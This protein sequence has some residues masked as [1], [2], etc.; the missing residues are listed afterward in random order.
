MNPAPELS[1]SSPNY[2]NGMNDAQLQQLCLDAGAKLSHAE[3]IKAY[4]FR[5]GIADWH[6]MPELPR[7]LKDYLDAHVS[8]LEPEI[9]ALQN[10]D[11]GTIKMLLKMDDGKEV[12]SVL[13][14]GT[15]R[16]TQ[17]ISTQIG[18]AVGCEFCLTA[19]AGL[20]RNLSC[21][22]MVAEVMTARRLTKTPARNLVLMGMGEPLHN[23]DEVSKFVRLATDPKGMAFSPRRVTLS[24]AGLVPQIYRMMEDGLNCSLAVSLNASNDATRNEIMPI[25]R[26]YPMAMLLE[27]LRAYVKEHGRK[28]VLIEYVMLAGVNDQ[29]E[30]AG[31]LIQ[32]LDGI[33]STINLLPFNAFPGSRWQRPDD[34]TVS[35]FRSELSAADFVAVVRESRGRDISA[36]CGQLKTEVTQRRAQQQNNDRRPSTK[37]NLTGIPKRALTP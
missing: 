22:E 25:N 23:Y 31:E 3:T 11:D 19:T 15:G 10:S 35:R 28:R 14:P 12:E 36:A 18:C 32:A 30:H 21:A 8:V 2:I 37:A 34:E 4:L 1:P 6:A 33:A 5:R 9:S 29:P 20:T 17:C 13:I 27:A 7:A 24:T 16:L 26:K